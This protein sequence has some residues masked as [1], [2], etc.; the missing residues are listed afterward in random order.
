MET[1]V[2]TPLPGIDTINTCGA[3]AARLYRDVGPQLMISGHWPP[4]WVDDEY[5]VLV[6]AEADEQDRLHRELLPGETGIGADG[7]LARIAPYYSRAD[8]GSVV[9]LRVR[10]HNPTTAAQKAVLR[11]VVPVGW[12][13][14]PDVA[15]ISLP[16]RGSDEIE[17]GVTAGA[18][19]RRARLAVD[20]SIGELHLGQH[21]EAIVDVR[22]RPT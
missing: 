19:Q 11:M 22:A 18:P 12:V 17:I 15:A 10:V 3:P 20:V 21:A 8:T 4:R 14:V 7:V 2:F 5:L 9:R 1:L 16:P 13:A 6:A